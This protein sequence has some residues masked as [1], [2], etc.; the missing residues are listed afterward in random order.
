MPLQINGFEIENGTLI[1]YRG[2]ASDVVIPDSVQA[3]AGGAFTEFDVNTGTL[4]ASNI[5]SV[6][7][8]ENVARIDENAFSDCPYLNELSVSEE[9]KHYRSENNCIIELST[10]SLIRGTSS[11]VIPSDG[12]VTSI[13]AHAFAFCK[14]MTSV[15]LPEGIAEI[16]DS[17]FG[18][19]ILLRSVKLPSTLRYLGLTVFGGCDALENI[20][21][22]KENTVY[23]SDGNCL[24]ETA[25]KKLVQGIKTS[26]IPNDGSVEI[27]GRRAFCL[28]R[29]LKNLTVP[30]S[31]R[32]IEAEAFDSCPLLSKL[33]IPENT[34]VL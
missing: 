22:A 24:I 13:A 27:I 8:S 21:V 26:I 17:A 23:S 6:Y 9:N 4:R 15:E 32:L 29:E 30:P 33:T 28:C 7:I 18:D 34:T 10:K 25:E 14:N 31:V 12:S 2:S 1:K 11:S 5:T 3:I 19:C 16:G 20:S